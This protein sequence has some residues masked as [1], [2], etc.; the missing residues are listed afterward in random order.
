MTPQ[1]SGTPSVSA[2]FPALVTPS[3]MKREVEDVDVGITSELSGQ[4]S[5][6]READAEVDD[7]TGI[8]KRRIAPTLVSAPP[9]SDI[10]D[11]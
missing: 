5:N 4:P 6:K 9:D 1:V 8:K 11:A 7:S 10:G 2:S 3:T